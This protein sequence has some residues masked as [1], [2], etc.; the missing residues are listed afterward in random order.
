MSKRKADLQSEQPTTIREL[1]LNLAAQLSDEAEQM[2]DLADRLGVVEEL[3]VAIKR[4]RELEADMKRLQAERDRVMAALAETQ[5]VTHS[6]A[7]R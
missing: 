4:I 5:G 2:L 6:A 3:D 7:T 1:A